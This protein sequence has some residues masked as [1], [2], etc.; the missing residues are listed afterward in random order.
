MGGGRPDQDGRFEVRGL[1]VGR[2]Y[3][4]ALDCLDPGAGGDREFPGRIRD[5][6]TAFGLNDGQVITLDLKLVNGL[7]SI[8]IDVTGVTRWE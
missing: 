1:P 7:Y 8:R 5:R 6:A 3:A 2:Y 4:T